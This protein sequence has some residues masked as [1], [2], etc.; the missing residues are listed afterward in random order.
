MIGLRCNSPKSKPS[1]KITGDD[2]IIVSTINDDFNKKLPEPPIDSTSLIQEQQD[3]VRRIHFYK[4]LAINS[5][6]KHKAASF[7]I[8]TTH[9]EKELHLSFRTVPFQKGKVHTIIQIQ[10]ENGYLPILLLQKTYNTWKLNNVFQ[11]VSFSSDS[12]IIDDYNFDGINDLA[13]Q[14]YYSSGRCNCSTGCYSVYLYNSNKHS[15]ISRKS[16]LIWM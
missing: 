4:K 1:D 6:K 2:T 16:E 12:V 3:S 7:F 5:L 10:D 11:G 15:V 14:W 13:I 8:D 9:E